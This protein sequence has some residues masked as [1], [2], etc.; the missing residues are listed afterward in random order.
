MSSDFSRRV[1]FGHDLMH[2]DH[3]VFAPIFRD[4]LPSECEKFLAVALQAGG[5]P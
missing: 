5:S 4:P 3:T 2:R 1:V